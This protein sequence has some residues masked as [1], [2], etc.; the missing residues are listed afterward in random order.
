MGLAYTSA[1]TIQTEFLLRYDILHSYFCIW[2][3]VWF[4]FKYKSNNSSD[5]EFELN[6]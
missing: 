4:K 5:L 1:V 3:E 2:T 6:Q